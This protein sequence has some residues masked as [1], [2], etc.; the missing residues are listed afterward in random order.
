VAASK[1][2]GRLRV[3]RRTLGRGRWA[4]RWRPPAPR[5]SLPHAPSKT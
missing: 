5:P 3:S 4:S 1:Q 2:P